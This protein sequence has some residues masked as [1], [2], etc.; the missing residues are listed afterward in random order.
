MNYLSKKVFIVKTLFVVIAVML[1]SSINVFAISVTY[2]L[3]DIGISLTLPENVNTITRENKSTDD[4]FHEVMSYE[5]AQKYMNDNNIYLIA[6]AFDFSYTLELQMVKSDKSDDS[7]LNDKILENTSNTEL[8]T[9][10]IGDIDYYMY[11]SSTQ[12]ENGTTTYVVNASTLQNGEEFTLK[13]L[14]QGDE[15][16]QEEMTVFNDVLTSTEYT[17]PTPITDTQEATTAIDNTQTGNNI[18]VAS[19]VIN[20][21]VSVAILAIIL[22]VIVYAKTNRRNA[23]NVQVNSSSDVDDT[24]NTFIDDFY[25]EVSSQ[26]SRKSDVYDANYSS[27]GKKRAKAIRLEIEVPADKIRVTKESKRIKRKMEE[28][29]DSVVLTN[30]NNE[31]FD[32]DIKEDFVDIESS[33]KNVEEIKDTNR[34]VEREFVGQDVIVQEFEKD[35]YWD[36][37][38]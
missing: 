31:D 13:I 19:I 2:S 5:D 14:S 18:N 22:G 20:L 30:S 21:V 15:V 32:E 27:S 33:S 8:T 38:R 10:Q 28:E 24:Q 29:K 11:K 35:D 37:Y 7:Y 36:K 1:L 12:D 3:K 17:T 25:D 9:S 6:T 23:I 4:V 26:S 16:T 34:K